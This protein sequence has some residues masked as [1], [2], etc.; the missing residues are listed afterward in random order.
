MTTEIEIIEYFKKLEAKSFLRLLKD[1]LEEY[2]Q[3][4]LEAYCTLSSSG[5][6][7]PNKQAILAVIKQ[8][9]IES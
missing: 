3:E 5:G 4:K 9:V 7:L 1:I 8:L 2:P 6:G